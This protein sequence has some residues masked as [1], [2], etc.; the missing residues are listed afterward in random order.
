M[1]LTNREALDIMRRLG[2]VMVKCT[3]HYRGRIEVDGKIVAMVHCSHGDK[4]MPGH[5]PDLFRKS[6]HLTRSE[7]EQVR[8]GKIGLEEYVELLRMKGIV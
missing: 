2:A 6:L 5:V 3:H 1:Q 7:F 4:S 8:R